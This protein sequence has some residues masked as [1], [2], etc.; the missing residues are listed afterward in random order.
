MSNTLHTAATGLSAQQQRIDT[1]ANNIANVNTGG[2]KRS[3][4]DFRDAVYSAM[5]NPALD[6][7][8]AAGRL[9]LG[10]GVVVSATRMILDDGPLMQTERMLDLALVGEGFFA[11]ENPDGPMLFS[12]DGT[13][14]SEQQPDGRFA[15]LTL[16]GNYVLDADMNRITSADPL[17]G[18][19]VDPS[20]RISVG[21][22][23]VADIGRFTF[24]NPQGLE[25]AGNRTYRATE[26]SG[27]PET[28]GTGIRQGFVEGSNV[29]LAE[30][31][32]QLL[33]AQRA[34]SLLS[35]AVTVADEMRATENEI[36]R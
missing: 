19:S 21:N 13:F 9:P 25:K 3:R 30:E 12:R 15:L 6:A 32:T 36:R 14:R 1:L 20:G 17:D 29:D 7:D 4:V 26:N 23:V 34:Y 27:E 18:M 10:H 24:T 5:Q 33:R 16:N 22:N 35:R 28:A 31:M 11:V 8:D 2:F